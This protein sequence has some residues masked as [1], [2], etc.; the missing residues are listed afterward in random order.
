MVA[1]GLSCG[2]RDLV[3]WPR[4]ETGPPALGARSLNHW[5]AREVP[6]YSFQKMF[7][8]S[9]ISLHL[10]I[11]SETSWNICLPCCLHFLSLPGHQSIP[12]GLLVPL[13]CFLSVHHTHWSLLHPRSSER[14]AEFSAV[15]HDLQHSSS[16]ELF[17]LYFRDP[18][19]SLLSSYLASSSFSV[20]L[21][22]F[23]PA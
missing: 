21:V 10:P 4:I 7:P 1:P 15:E 16:S 6:K 14:S 11:L 22:G 12:L 20:S 5:T 23:S 13:W 3:P 2:M 8:L 9:H 17:P 18:P 19:V